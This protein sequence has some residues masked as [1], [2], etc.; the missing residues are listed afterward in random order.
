M[1][2]KNGRDVLPP[3]LLNE[4]QKYLDG[5]LVYI[6]KCN[7]NKASWGTL[8]GTREHVTARNRCIAEKYSNGSSIIDLQDEY[9]LSESSIR[10]IIYK[11]TYKT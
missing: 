10:K 9:C 4:I 7:D 8:N 6:P 1:Q 3:E 5:E 2:Y 11:Y